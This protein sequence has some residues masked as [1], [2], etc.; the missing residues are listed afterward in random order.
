MS[1]LTLCQDTATELQLGLS[2]LASVYGSSYELPRRLLRLAERCGRQL[3][4]AKDWQVL[5]RTQTFTAVAGELQSAAMPADFGRFVPEATWDRTNDELIAG[6]IAAAE[7]SS[8]AGVGYT[9]SR[10]KFWYVNSECRFSPAFA[11]GESIAF[12]YVTSQ[13]IESSGGTGQTAFAADTDVIRL[14]HDLLV[15][16]MAM[17]YLRQ[18]GSPFTGAQKAYRDR[19]R[20]VSRN[21]RPMVAIQASEVPTSGFG[22]HF[23]GAPMADDAGDSSI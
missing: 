12:E 4:E 20:V 15:L 13:W 5:Q 18:E 22:R 2:E 19:M 6:P 17:E 10:R 1:L 11:G 7:R 14:D 9:G 21:E 16:A 8:R 23:R 3:A